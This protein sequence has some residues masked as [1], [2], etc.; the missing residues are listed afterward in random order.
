MT[1]TQQ[2]ALGIEEREHIVDTAR[3]HWFVLFANV[4]PSLIL[5]M[6]PFAVLAYLTSNPAL[7]AET[8]LAERT[9][10]LTSPVILYGA[11]I[12]VSLLWLKIFSVWMDYFLDVWITTDRRII[13]VEQGG[14]FHRE[15]SSFRFERIQDVT[16][17]IK[18]IFATLLDFGDL[19]VQTAGEARE[20]IIR[21]LP[22]PNRHKERILKKIQS[23][24]S[25]QQR[26]YHDPA[27]V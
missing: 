3:K 9:I 17:E 2:Q 1:R 12:W 11:L 8:P 23:I 13:D 4:L 16:V 6:L 7:F 20:F 10:D 26:T 27:D 19:H 18:G 25:A 21:G 24:S 15:V 5:L 22:H 14:F